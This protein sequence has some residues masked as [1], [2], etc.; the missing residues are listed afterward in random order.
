[1]FKM[2]NEGCAERPSDLPHRNRTAPGQ[3]TRSTFVPLS[4]ASRCPILARCEATRHRSARWLPYPCS[5]DRITLTALR[6]ARLGGAADRCH[7]LACPIP[8]GSSILGV[9][10]RTTERHLLNPPS[11]A[12]GPSPASASDRRRITAPRQI[13][14]PHGLLIGSPSNQLHPN[15]DRT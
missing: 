6:M 3:R 8:M 1:M 2:G 9:T 10:P 13:D 14:R 11:S 15:P 12:A 5:N 7:T 4:M